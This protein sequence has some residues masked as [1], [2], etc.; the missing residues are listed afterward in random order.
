MLMSM[1]VQ[2]MDKQVLTNIKRANISAE[3]MVEL[4]PTIH[5][6]GVNTSGEIIMGMP[7]QSYASVLDTIGQLIYGKVDDIIIHACMMLPGSEM[8]IPAERSK[9]KLK[10]KFRILPMDFAVLGN[11][12]K[13]CEIDEIVV[14]SKDMTFDDYVSC[15]KMDLLIETF[16][17]NALFEEFF[18]SLKTLGISEWECLVYIFEINY[19][20]LSQTF[21]DF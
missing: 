11:G 4:S 12:K 16:H 9:W 15:R 8:A 5:E 21:L 2:S 10:T 17:N 18:L 6:Y 14:S 3:K 1:S 20:R 7:G 19:K 13:I